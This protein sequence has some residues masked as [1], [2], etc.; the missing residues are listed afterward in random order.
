MDERWE[1]WLCPKC[2]LHALTPKDA[3]V[4]P[5]ACECATH[6]SMERHVEPHGFG[7]RVR[8]QR[9]RKRMTLRA[10]AKQ[11]GI[12][13]SHLCDVERDINQP[14]LKVAV[15]LSQSLQVPIGWL[16]ETE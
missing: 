16:A 1:H 6:P 13:A 2:G 3:N 12:S 7:A 9:S 4:E 10:L 5:W 14:S 15:A 11:T 8:W